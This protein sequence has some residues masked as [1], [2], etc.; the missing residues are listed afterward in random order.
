MRDETLSSFLNHFSNCK[1]P[2]YFHIK[3]FNFK[4]YQ[5]D[6]SCLNCD[7][8]CKFITNNHLE[9]NINFIFN[10][11]FFLTIKIPLSFIKM[12]REFLFEKDNHEKKHLWTQLNDFYKPLGY[13]RKASDL[14]NHNDVI[15]NVYLIKTFG[16]L[17]FFRN[18]NAKFKCAA[19]F[20]F[21]KEF[22]TFLI[23]ND[24]NIGAPIRTISNL[25]STSFLKYKSIQLN[26]SNNKVFFLEYTFDQ[27]N[28]SELL[29]GMDYMNFCNNF[30]K[31]TNEDDH[32]ISN[33]TVF[34]KVACF[35]IECGLL[36]Q[37]LY[38]NQDKLPFPT[39]TK[40]YVQCIVMYTLILSNIYME[41]TPKLYLLCYLPSHIVKNINQTLINLT[42]SLAKYNISCSDVELK[43]F[44]NELDLIN[45][46]FGN[47]AQYD[48]LIG[49]N[50]KSFDLSYLILRANILSGD[51]WYTNKYFNSY[52]LTSFRGELTTK[53]N[54]NILLYTRCGK[55]NTKIYINS[56]L[57]NFQGKTI[58]TCSCQN[59]CI[60]NN[61]SIDFEQKSPWYFVQEL[62]FTHHQDIIYNKQIFENTK[63]KKL[64]TVTNFNFRQKIKT[65]HSNLIHLQDVFTLDDLFILGTVFCVNIKLVVFKMF[66]HSYQIDEEE[67][68]RLVNI[69]IVDSKTG[70]YIENLKL[71]FKN[72]AQ[73]RMNLHLKG[74]QS[75]NLIFQVENL[76]YQQIDQNQ[77]S[78]FS[79]Y[80][81]VGKTTDQSRANQLLWKTEQNIIDTLIYCMIDVLLTIAIELKFHTLF[82]IFSSKFFK[83]CPFNV[84]SWRPARKSTFLA[85]ISRNKL[86]ADVLF[87]N[88]TIQK[89][90]NHSLAVEG[91]PIQDNESIYRLPALQNLD[92]FL[93]LDSNTLNFNEYIFGMN[94]T[95]DPSV[96]E[97]VEEN[98][99]LIVS[100]PKY[101]DKPNQ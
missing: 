31:L 1:L 45:Y 81:S 72:I 75:F 52:N 93:N 84:L 78:G 18:L 57:N 21:E 77:N 20:L 47:T 55:C 28:A 90:L 32:S 51:D 40:G 56:N 17:K 19:D 4:S 7:L 60:L 50:S 43:L 87:D 34:N 26:F 63:N 92:E 88:F 86:C 3:S 16:E 65:I 79:F 48:Y 38:E 46:F 36:N 8:L 12:P 33:L 95:Y 6:S 83:N 37:H 76:K 42:F 67:E 44:D 94:G 13:V 68:C 35:D 39:F 91:V 9:Q 69:I 27:N 10:V 64:E 41:E 22:E 85:T 80:V 23:Q 59:T 14:T 97:S 2:K 30:W 54:Q 62:P 53:T 73:A 98:L 25:L 74:I 49:F 89:I 99:S 5:P 29:S 101:Q 11:K 96:L 61:D 66:N 24:L 100:K 71:N 82:D 58:V 15:W 70:Q